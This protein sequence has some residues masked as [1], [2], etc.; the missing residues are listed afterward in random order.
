[1]FI[2]N[3]YRLKALNESSRLFYKKH[4]LIMAVLL[5]ICG[6]CCLIYPFMAGLYLSY[7]TGMMFM[8]CGFYTFYSLIVF[9][10]QHW[11]SKFVSAVFAL[12]WL[13]LGYG[14]IINPLVGMNSLSVIFCC[15]FIIGGI[16]RIVSG[17][18]MRGRAGYTW[19]ILIGIFDLLIAALWLGL[20]PEQSY[21]FTTIFI[22]LEMIFSAGGFISLRKKL[23]PAQPNKLALKDSQ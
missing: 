14:F 9:R 17:F 20:D 23:S 5:L 6:A 8:I 22:G 15:L 21:L 18:R 3:Q 11:K 16:S 12:A 19:S 2:F 7:I 10:K 13:L 4:S 1:M